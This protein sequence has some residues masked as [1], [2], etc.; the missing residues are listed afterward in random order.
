MKEIEV[1]KSRKFKRITGKEMSETE[2]ENP[3]TD[4][5]DI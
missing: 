2:R 4:W 1:G 3:A 5:E